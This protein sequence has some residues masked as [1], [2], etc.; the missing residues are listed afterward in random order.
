MHNLR[1]SQ[2]SYLSVEE[3]KDLLDKLNQ[4][5]LLLVKMSVQCRDF[6]QYSASTIVTSALYSSTAFLKHS[7]Q[8]KG[9]RTSRFVNEVR[10]IIFQIVS[11]ELRQHANF[12]GS[13]HCEPSTVEWLE[14]R[15]DLYQRQ[16]CQRFIEQIAMDLV[17]YY[18]AFDEW[19]CGLNQLKKY[20]RVP[21]V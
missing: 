14:E 4:M 15:Q 7:R 1:M 11:D 13:V 16:Y 8:H 12:L 9:E 6:L 10:K 5:C 2:S 19:H 21:F 3:A 17:D 18:K 20:N